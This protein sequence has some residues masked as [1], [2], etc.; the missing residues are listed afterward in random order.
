MDGAQEADILHIER[1]F[2]EVPV[3]LNH[4]RQAVNRGGNGERGE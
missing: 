2:E 1:F 3:L 4:L